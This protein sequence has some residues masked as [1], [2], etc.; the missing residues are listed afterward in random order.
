MDSLINDIRNHLDLPS[1][2]SPR[3][4]AVRA[5]LDPMVDR[6]QAAFGFDFVN[7]FTELFAELHEDNDEQEFRLGFVTGARLMMEIMT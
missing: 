4:A 2:L 5:R 6:V 3:R 7:D 1:E